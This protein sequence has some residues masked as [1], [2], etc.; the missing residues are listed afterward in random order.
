MHPTSGSPSDGDSDDSAIVIGAEFAAAVEAERRHQNRLRGAVRSPLEGVRYDFWAGD[1]DLLR[2]SDAP[3]D[4]AVEAAVRRM[5][6]STGH[7][8][9]QLRAA[10]SMDDLYTLIGF[11]RRAAVR[12]LRQGSSSAA[13]DA[14]FAAALV[15]TARIDWRD[16]LV[17]LGVAS[18]ALRAVSP[19]ATATLRR[20]RDLALPPTAQ[21][22][23]RFVDPSDEDADLSSWGLVPVETRD[24]LGLAECGIEHYEPSRDLVGLAIS[25]ADAIDADDYRVSAIRLAEDLA[26]VWLPGAPPAEADHVLSRCHGCVTV[27]ARLRPP[28]HPESDSQQLTLFIVETADEADARRLAGWS[29]TTPSSMHQSLGWQAGDLFVLL[30]ARSFVSGVAA[31]ESSESLDRFDEPIS[32]HIAAD[33]RK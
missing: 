26:P 16:A 30:I 6:G 2:F 28:T 24:G 7:E 9:D 31:Y 32:A 25:I 10:L 8:R 22:I 5:A 14:T 20:A 11:A 21:L 17:A 15:D 1:H 23:D 19:E 12:A 3:A 13:A 33:G 27:T 4:A 29:A 18:Y